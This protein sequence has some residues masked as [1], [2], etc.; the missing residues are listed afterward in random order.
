MRSLTVV[1]VFVL[2]FSRLRN[3]P[4]ESL[5]RVI[6]LDAFNQR[7]DTATARSNRSEVEVWRFQ[8]SRYLLSVGGEQ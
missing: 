4:H 3:V 8:V 6:S 7:S 5:A 1:G 2:G